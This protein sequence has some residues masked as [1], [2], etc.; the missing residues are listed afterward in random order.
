MTTTLHI[1]RL[2]PQAE[3]PARATAL[4]AGFDVRVC[5]HTTHVKVYRDPLNGSQAEIQR[6]I[7]GTLWLRPGD[8]ALIPTGL[9]MRPA[10][11]YC[12]KFYPRS[13]ISLKQGLTLINCV[14]V[15]DED[16][17]QEYYVTLV[18]HSS[19]VQSIADGMRLC[20]L[21]VE[22]VEPVEV[23]ECDELPAVQSDRKGGF[24]ST[25]QLDLP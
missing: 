9:A 23:V 25:G 12:I 1:K 15:G 24:G 16:Y 19:A 22:R 17:E 3:L 8:R 13:G 14:G 2:V 11:G 7:S 4:A 6:V 10:A 20:Q 21:M 5:L 18:N